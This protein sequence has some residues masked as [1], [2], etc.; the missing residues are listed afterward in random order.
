MLP[1]P[2]APL[3]CA[4][5]SERLSELLDGERDAISL[6]RVRHHVSVCPSCARDA[7]EL[8]VTVEAM[9]RLARPGGP[10]P[11]RRRLR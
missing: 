1:F 6:D 9:H 4:E 3:R 2:L 7:L 5:L 8:I 10:A 11:G